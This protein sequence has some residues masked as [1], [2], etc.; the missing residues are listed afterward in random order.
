MIFYTDLIDIINITYDG[1]GVSTKNIITDVPARV[2]DFNK[3]IINDKGQEVF[4]EMIVFLKASYNITEESK[5][6]IK[7]KAK[8]NYSNTKEWKVKKT[9][10]VHAF[11]Y[12][13]REVYL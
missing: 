10:V 9:P 7:K 6:I 11:S 5:I 8:N 1:N 4:A 2:E 3:L 12:H 13:H